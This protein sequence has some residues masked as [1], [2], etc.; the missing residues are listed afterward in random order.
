MSPSVVVDGPREEKS[1]TSG[2][3]VADSPGLTGLIAA[4]GVDAEPM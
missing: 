3:R 2:T 4:V 1:A